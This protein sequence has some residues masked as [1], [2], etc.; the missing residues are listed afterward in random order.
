MC[1]QRCG[2]HVSRITNTRCHYQQAIVLGLLQ[3]QRGRMLLKLCRLVT[4]HINHERH[5]LCL[6]LPRGFVSPGPFQSL[7]REP[8]DVG[9]QQGGCLRPAGAEDAGAVP[10]G[11]LCGQ[12]F[13]TQWVLGAQNS[14]WSWDL[15]N[16]SILFKMSCLI[17]LSSSTNHKQWCYIKHYCYY[18]QVNLHRN[19]KLIVIFGEK[20]TWPHSE[21]LLNIPCYSH[22]GS[23][24]QE[25][26]LL[27]KGYYFRQPS[28][29]QCLLKQ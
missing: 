23:Q 3:K 19:N 20:K 25:R 5:P 2:L 14:V 27:P 26:F 10:A 29:K 16:N 6:C 13:W 1:P 8:A 15:L 17:P 22:T 24:T 4:Y 9:G 12:H 11:Y 7:H 21:D 18:R 28:A